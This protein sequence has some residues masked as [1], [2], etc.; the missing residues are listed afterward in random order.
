MRAKGHARLR[1]S[2]RRRFRSHHECR[3]LELLS[4]VLQRYERRF[5]TDT[6]G[7]VEWVMHARS[8]EVQERARMLDG[9]ATLVSRSRG[10]LWESKPSAAMEALKNS[11]GSNS[12]PSMRRSKCQILSI[13]SLD[14]YDPHPLHKHPT[15]ITMTDGIVPNSSSASCGSAVS[16][17]PST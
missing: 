11:R 2:R 17:Y 1:E 4:I 6:V 13:T 10:N 3:S 9:A 15:T 8:R 12:A 16:L 14:P 5:I 7:N